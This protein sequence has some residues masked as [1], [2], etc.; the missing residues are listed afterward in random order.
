MFR[1]VFIAFG[2]FCTATLFAQ[3][4]HTASQVSIPKRNQWIKEKSAMLK[5]FKPNAVIAK[6]VISENEVTNG[7]NLS[8]DINDKGYLVTKDSGWIYFITHSAHNNPKVGDITLAIDNSKNIFI[9]EGHVCGG[10]A[11]FRALN[12]KEVNSVSDFFQYFNSEEKNGQW[13]KVP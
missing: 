5:K 10:Y 6:A 11:S 2:I 13:K 8:V 4:K 9:N 1:L 7:I 12:F 3:E